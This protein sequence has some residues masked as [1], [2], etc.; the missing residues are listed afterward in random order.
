TFGTSFSID[1]GDP[2]PMDIFSA[3]SATIDLTNANITPILGINI[4]PFIRSGT[5][6]LTGS[7]VDTPN[8]LRALPLRLSC[9]ATEPT[10]FYLIKNPTI[11]GNVFPTPAAGDLS[12][13]AVASTLGTYTANTGKILGVFYTGQMDGD[14]IDLT[15]I[16]SYNREY[17]AREAQISANSPG[18]SLY[19]MARRLGS[20]TSGATASLVW[21]QQ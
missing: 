20:T 10:A 8:Q 16:F 18:D 1:A 5:N 13:V 14:T 4:K 17:L 21:G 11:A 3:N 6:T 15:S 7:S 19:V 9:A 12:A 2:S